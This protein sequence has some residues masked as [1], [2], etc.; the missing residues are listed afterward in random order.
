ML[1]ETLIYI[2]S[3]IIIAWGIAHLISKDLFIGKV[4]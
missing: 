1:N 3:S 2:G 4:L